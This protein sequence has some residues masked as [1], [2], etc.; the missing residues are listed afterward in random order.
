MTGTNG[1]TSD[2]SKGFDGLSA[3]VTPEKKKRRG[4]LKWVLIGV[5]LMGLLIGGCTFV[6]FK[7][8]E[9]AENQARAFTEALLAND[10]DRA[11]ALTSTDFKESTSKAALT[12]LGGRLN[13]QLDGA[14]LKVDG[15]SIAKS[16]G[17]ATTSTITYTATKGDVKA[18]FKVM[19]SDTGKQGWRVVNFESSETPFADDSSTDS[20]DATKTTETGT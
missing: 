9:K 3:M 17:S 20:A 14:S 19:L 15:R 16:S 5:V 2:S 1:A 18:Y 8:T 7:G 4:C 12:E 13:S 11:Y 6:I 10:V